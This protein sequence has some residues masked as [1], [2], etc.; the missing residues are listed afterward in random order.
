M[1]DNPNAIIEEN[2]PIKILILGRPGVGKTSLKSIIFENKT[3][4]DTFKLGSTNEIQELHLNF[5]NNF[6]V[7]ILDF[8]SK[9]DY[10]KQYFTTKKE[11]IFSN[12]GALIFVVEP[13]TNNI[14]NEPENELTYFEK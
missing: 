11:T 10:T 8:S 12:V 4:N 14:K 13:E 1:E 2:N 9:D 7:T 6:P 5:L 3:P